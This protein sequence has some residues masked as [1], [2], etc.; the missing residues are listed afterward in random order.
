MT[1]TPAR[2]AALVAAGTAAAFVLAACGSDSKAVEQYKDAPISSRNEAAAVVGTMPDGFNNWAAKCDGP[3]RVYT[4][5]HFKTT[6]DAADGA[7]GSIA[8]VP[9]DPRCTSK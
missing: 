8:V 2:R 9:N 1:K 3:N 4:I 7:Y 6:K 5:F